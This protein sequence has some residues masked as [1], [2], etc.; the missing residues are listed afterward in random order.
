MAASALILIGFTFRY[1]LRIHPR[2]LK[3]HIR[4]LTRPMEESFIPLRRIVEVVIPKEAEEKLNA[5]F[6]EEPMCQGWH[7]SSQEE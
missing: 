2:E 7:R 1:M 6:P 5:F 4:E 3:K